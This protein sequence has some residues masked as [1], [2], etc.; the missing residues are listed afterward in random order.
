MEDIKHS[1]E[2][3]FQTKY[4]LLTAIFTI[5]AMLQQC[6]PAS[7]PAS[8]PGDNYVITKLYNQPDF[9]GSTRLSV[10]PW[11][12]FLVAVPP[13]LNPKYILGRKLVCK[14]SFQIAVI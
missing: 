8:E 1:V 7:Q 2:E 13:S 12:I 11:S 6:S 3:G 14:V 9:K 4:N 5:P 10:L